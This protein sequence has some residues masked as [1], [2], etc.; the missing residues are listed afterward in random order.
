[1]TATLPD[2]LTQS[3][4]RNISESVEV[5]QDSDGRSLVIAVARDAVGRP[6]A[7]TALTGPDPYEMTGA[8]PSRSVQPRPEYTKSPRRRPALDDGHPGIDHR[9]GTLKQ[10]FGRLLPRLSRVS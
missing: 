7:T 8:T 6:P 9:I 2:G 3:R 10:T 1:M 4:A 5:G